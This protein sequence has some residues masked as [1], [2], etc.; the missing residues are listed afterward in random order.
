MCGLHLAFVGNREIEGHPPLNSQPLN[1]AWCAQV[2]REVFTWTESNFWNSIHGELLWSCFPVWRPKAIVKRTGFVMV[3]FSLFFL[4]PF[5]LMQSSV[6][7]VWNMAFDFILDNVQVVLQ[8]TYGSTLKVI[9]TCSKELDESL[10][11][12]ASCAIS[13]CEVFAKC[14]IVMPWVFIISNFFLNN[15]VFCTFLFRKCQI[16]QYCM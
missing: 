13:A 15:K 9:W 8:Q 12:S 1:K 14:M 10:E 3:I 5:R 4:F 2:E 6:E 11:L 16:C 7:S